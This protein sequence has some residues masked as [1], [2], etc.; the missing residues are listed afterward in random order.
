[1]AFYLGA[2]VLLATWQVEMQISRQRNS[3]SDDSAGKEKMQA[4]SAEEVRE[5]D[6]RLDQYSLG[7]DKRKWWGSKSRDILILHPVSTLFEPGVLN[8]IMGPSG[9]GKTSLLN[10]MANR[11]RDDFTTRYKSDGKMLFNGA[12]PSKEV[13]K[14]LCSFVTQDDDALLPSLTVRETL[15]YVSTILGCL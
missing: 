7:I 5:V 1:M 13:I 11:L 6:I 14:S 15:R 9:S 12:E 3:D 10:S 2:A 4:R 8:V